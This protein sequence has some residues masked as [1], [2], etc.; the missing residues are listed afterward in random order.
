MLP[1][2]SPGDVG[3][4]LTSALGITLVMFAEAIGPARSFAGKHHDRIG[5][6][7]ELIGLGAA[8]FGAGLFQG[9]PIGASLSKSAANDASTPAMSQMSGLIAA[10]T[11]GAGRTLFHAAL[12]QLARGDPGRNRHCC[13]LRHVQAGE[14]P[15]ALPGAPAGFLVCHGRAAR[16]THL[17]GG[18]G[19]PADRRGGFVAGSGCTHQP[20]RHQRAGTGAGISTS[21]MW[22]A[23]RRASGFRVCLFCGP[24]RASSLP[25]PP[26][27]AT[28]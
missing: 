14:A 6:D 17:R 5:A 4:L 13:R 19:R 22:A 9:F 26:A 15:L 8:D 2:V 25:T 10:G 11:D 1:D 18:V 28:Q 12:P 24:T 3:L 20:P 7:Q 27:C 21:T 16:R 23:I